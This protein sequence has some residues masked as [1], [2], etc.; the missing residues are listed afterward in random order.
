MKKSRPADASSTSDVRAAIG[1]RLRAVREGIGESQSKFAARMEVT[2]LSV[3]TYES[4]TNS[5][6]ADQLC[7]L[8][9]AGVDG[10]YVAFGIPSLGTVEARRQ[11]A[12][13]LAW[14]KHE[15]MSS[16][17]QVSDEGLVEAAWFV[18]S[19]LRRR[20]VMEPTAVPELRS[21][22]RSAL[23][24]LHGAVGGVPE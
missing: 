19:E 11:F 15:C 14:V 12:S 5:P 7:M 24:A 16:S 1:R 4:G 20:A 10:S 22:A 13:A 2:K 9:A 21:E 6:R 18:F 8:E 23:D 17:L 3:L